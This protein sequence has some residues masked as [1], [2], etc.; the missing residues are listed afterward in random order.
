VGEKVEMGQGEHFF[1]VVRVE[2]YCS[3]GMQ[4]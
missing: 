1:V 3:P 2:S 4:V